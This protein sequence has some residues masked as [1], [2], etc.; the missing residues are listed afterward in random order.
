[1]YN[2]LVYFVLIVFVFVVLSLPLILGNTTAMAE[3]IV[4]SAQDTT[5]ANNSPTVGGL[6]TVGGTTAALCASIVTATEA[7]G[8]PVV[9]FDLEGGTGDDG[10]TAC[11]GS[12]HQI[13]TRQS[14]TA[15][16][17]MV[18]AQAAHDTTA[19]VVGPDG[20]PGPTPVGYVNDL[21]YE[22][23]K[24]RNV[25]W[26]TYRKKYNW[27]QEFFVDQAA[28]YTTA[29]ALQDAIRAQLRAATTSTNTTIQFVYAPWDYL[30]I[31]TVQVLQD[32]NYTTTKVYGADI[33][34]EDIQA[35]IAPQSPWFATAGGHPEM[36]GA[37]LLRMN[38]LQLANASTNEFEQMPSFLFTQEFLLQEQVTNLDELLIAM[39]EL[40]M[41]DIASACWI[42]PL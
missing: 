8:I 21:H 28:T 14:D 3:H 30:A 27:E 36:I 13:R 16:A 38:L 2:L 22:P 19:G 17:D 42:D 34:N 41:Q 32:D 18:L 6:I 11:D 20:R 7:A 1:M 25:E 35:M 33:N 31:N 15:I 24:I 40:R 10:T 29:P 12:T 4:A 5:E 23:L 26:E 39:P 9:S 37:A